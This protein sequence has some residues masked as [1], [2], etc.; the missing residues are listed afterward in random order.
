MTPIF[1]ICTLLLQMVNDERN[2]V[3]EIGSSKGK[4]NQEHEWKSE[5]EIPKMKARIMKKKK[6]KSVS[7]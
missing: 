1:K 7:E 6:S 2:R 5:N 4:K 3:H